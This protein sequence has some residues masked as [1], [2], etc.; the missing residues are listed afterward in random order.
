MNAIAAGVTTGVSSP[1]ESWFAGDGNDTDTLGLG[2]GEAGG[3]AVR[4]VDIAV[5]E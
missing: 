1:G 3:R 4:V 5:D 2:D